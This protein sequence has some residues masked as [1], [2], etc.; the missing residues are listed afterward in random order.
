MADDYNRGFPAEYA[1]AYDELIKNE[2]LGYELPKSTYVPP[3]PVEPPAEPAAEAEAAATTAPAAVPAQ[4]PVLATGDFGETVREPDISALSKP[5]PK[6]DPESVTGRLQGVT[7]DRSAL[8]GEK[9]PTS[10]DTVPMAQKPVAP[11]VL[12]PVPTE[13]EKTEETPVPEETEET[14]AAKETKPN[15]IWQALFKAKQRR[16]EKKAEKKKKKEEEG[17]TADGGGPGGEGTSDISV[18]GTDQG[19]GGALG[20]GK[21]MGPVADMNKDLAKKKNKNDEDEDKDDG[22]NK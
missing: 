7:E 19:I 22:E 10:L 15:I 2:D 20:R 3:P 21:N 11:D 4:A 8:T 1:V 17:E 18:P 9:T 14:E 16:A 12:T 13:T 6:T 5:I